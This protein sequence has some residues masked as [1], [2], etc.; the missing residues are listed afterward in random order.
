M[1]GPK[2]Q[3]HPEVKKFSD[4][5]KSSGYK[6]GVEDFASKLLNT[7]RHG[8]YYALK[9][10]GLSDG[11]KHIIVES[12]KNGKNRN[13]G[14][15]DEALSLLESIIGVDIP[16]ASGDNITAKGKKIN[17]KNTDIRIE[18]GDYK[19]LYNQAIKELKEKENKISELIGE[20][21]AYKS[22]YEELIAKTKNNA[23]LN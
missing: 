13:H 21:N 14:I 9:H 5:I 1:K 20:R 4:F 22:L 19:D 2:N 11:Q 3:P 7:N 6:G 18:G 8:M 15:R 16:R 12:L 17:I 23:S 10:G